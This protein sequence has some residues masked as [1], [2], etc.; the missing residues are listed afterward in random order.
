VKHRIVSNPVL[1]F[2][3]AGAALVAIIA[4]YRA[5]P[6]SAQCDG[7]RIMPDGSWEYDPSL[8]AGGTAGSSIPITPKIWTAIAASKKTLGTGT[9][10]QERSQ[11]AA[12]LDAIAACNSTRNTNDCGV[13][14]TGANSCIAFAVS[15]NWKVGFGRGLDY[16]TADHTAISNCNYNGGTNCKV[17]ADPCSD[18]KP[19]Q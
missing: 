15:E 12:K 17:T 9:S 8:C 1:R 3:V 14:M 7:M 4:S 16:I 18:D 11:E 10:W 5:T 6:A 2:I 13:V 19:S